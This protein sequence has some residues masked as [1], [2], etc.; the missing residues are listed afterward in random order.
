MLTR[1]RSCNVLLK[2]C[3]SEC[4]FQ[5]AR[6]KLLCEFA[7]T[8]AEVGRRKRGLRTGEVRHVVECT[9]NLQTDREV[10]S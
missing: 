4:T 10:A 7:F 1:Y 5:S 3:D 2:G 6:E 8:E 9:V